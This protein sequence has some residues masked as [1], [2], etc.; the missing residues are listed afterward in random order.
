MRFLS[1]VIAVVLS[2]GA[3]AQTPARTWTEPRTGLT[4]VWIPKGCF[5]MG[6]DEKI[7]PQG[8]ILWVHLGAERD[9]A[10]DE[11][12]SHEVCVDG[13]WIAKTETRQSDWHKVMA[14]KSES[15]T[16][17]IPVTD[18]TWAQARAFADR[19]SSTSGNQYRFRLPTEAEWEYACRA[20][21]T[22]EPL[23]VQ[24]E[25][26]DR[27]WYNKN[28]NRKAQP[29]EVAKLAPNA[30]GLHD[31]LGNAWEW[32]EDVYATDAYSRHALHNPRS[33]GTAES[34]VIRGGSHRSESNNIRC[35][36]R[37]SYPASEALRTVG[38]RLVRSE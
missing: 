13:F 9:F 37:G 24:Q 10:Y 26:A 5:Q 31:M 7:A 35:A 8:D 12:P 32:V 3:Y 19:L 25:A 34:R 17:N 38:F 1:L 20:G 28:E 11:H 21:A 6:T 14:S 15:K 30:F 4:F 16:P 27:A 33:E 36:N 29:R 18:V 23:P 2:V 22:T